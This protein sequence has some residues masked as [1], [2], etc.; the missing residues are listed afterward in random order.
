MRDDYASSLIVR[1]SDPMA[2]IDLKGRLITAAFG[3]IGYWCVSFAAL[4]EDGA[5][6]RVRLL[7]NGQQD[8]AIDLV[9]IVPE[10]EPISFDARRIGSR[11]IVEASFA[12]RVDGIRIDAENLITGGKLEFEISLDQLLV[13][14]HYLPALKASGIS[15]DGT[16]IKIE[17]DGNNY[18]DGV[19]FVELAIREEG[20]EDWMPLINVDGE[21]YAFCVA[22][23]SSRVNLDPEYVAEWLPEG[24]AEIFVRLSRVIGIPIASECRGSVND[25]LLHAWRRLGESLAN[26]SSSDQASLLKACA[27]PPSVHARESWLPRHHPL[28]IAPKLFAAPAEEFGQLASSELDGYDEFE[29]VGL[30]GITESLDDAREL[31][32]ISPAFLAAFANAATINTT[33]DMDP[34][35]FD[36]AKYHQF[37]KFLDDDRLLSMRCHRR[38]CERIA[39]RYATTAMD[40]PSAGPPHPDAHSMGKAMAAV[41][42]FKSHSTHSLD[43]SPE[44]A[45]EFPSIADTPRLISALAQAS[46]DGRVD[47]FWNEVASYTSRSQEQVRKDVGLVLRIAPELLAFYLLLWELVERTRRGCPT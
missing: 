5:H 2:A 20:R 34:G 46:R 32:D 41:R 30:A 38:F 45:E 6:N 22:P 39:D 14:T 27:I 8:S 19:W 3:K 35:E 47:Q 4:T 17:L 16:S 25:L 13:D 42:H 33:A 36:F 12:R 31:L 26:G 9:R 15:E 1:Y 7:R 28:E 11:Q 24:A 44:L 43:V 10:T 21:L 18:R 37:A 29:A 23:E 40:G